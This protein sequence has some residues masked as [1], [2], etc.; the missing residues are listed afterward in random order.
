MSFLDINLG[1]AQEPMTV[2]EGEYALVIRSAELKTKQKDEGE[3]KHIAIRLEIEG[4]TAAKDINHV[5]M[6]PA[7]RGNEKEDNNRKWQLRC[8]CEAFDIPFSSG[9]DLA[10]FPG[11]RGWAVITETEDPQ[12]G[13]QNRIRQVVRKG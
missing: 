3:S 6:L 12:Y 2:A 4:E 10:N 9:I 8:F 11:Q 1:D 7:G 13:K 5:I